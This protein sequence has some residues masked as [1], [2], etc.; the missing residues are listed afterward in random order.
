PSQEKTEVPLSWD[1]RHSMILSMD[2][3]TDLVQIN[4]I[5]RL[6]SPLPFTTPGSA[7][8]NNARQSWRNIL[9]LRIKFKSYGALGGQLVPFVDI[10]NV[11]DEENVVNVQDD[12]GIRA[13]RLF[14]PMNT[15]FGRRL[16]VGMKL[17][18]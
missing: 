13:Y 3:D 11:F 10:R 16:R 17:D 5:Y 15:N 6:F 9:D 12:T 18:L 14:D 8:P 7:I 1:Q 4:A 2:Y